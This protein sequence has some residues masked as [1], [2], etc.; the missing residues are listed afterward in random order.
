[1]VSSER[2]RWSVLSLVGLVLFV[3]TPAFAVQTGDADLAPVGDE[4]GASGKV[5]LK[6]TVVL[7]D[8]GSGFEVI[9]FH[10]KCTGLTPGKIYDFN[11]TVPLIGGSGEKGVADENG[12][13]SI[14]GYFFAD[15]GDTPGYAFVDRLDING[16]TVSYQTVLFGE[17][18]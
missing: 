7:E 12:N 4:R 11:V 16:Y 1:M 17:I 13:L 18:V 9:D 3:A 15:V 8:N 14:K 6:E 10:V 2:V 5:T